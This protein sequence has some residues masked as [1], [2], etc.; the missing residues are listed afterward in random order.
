MI[1][2]RTRAI[3][4]VVAIEAWHETFDGRIAKADLHADVSFSLGRMG[5]QA[6]ARISFRLALRQAEVVLIVPESEGLK[7]D[8]KSV[9]REQTN[10]KFEASSTSKS[11]SSRQ[12]MA[13]VKGAIGLKPKLDLNGQLKASQ[14][15][16]RA[17]T[18]KTT[19]T[20]PMIVAHSQTSDGHHCWKI[21]AMREDGLAGQPW[22]PSK[23]R[24]TLIDSQAGRDRSIVPCVR[25]EVRCRREDLII[26]DIQV[27]DFTLLEQL[28]AAVLHRN[29][30]V[31][32]ECFIRD[33]LLK[34]GLGFSDLNNR[35]ATIVLASTT[36]DA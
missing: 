14:T 22:K 25:L 4:E 33:E 10:V 7:I 23:A 2:N 19:V 35:F 36:T 3:A 34:R 29:K 21:E 27:V 32:A 1:G 11:K 20:Q 16:E 13:A 15:I 30:E 26:S 31:A 28:K 5:D 12:I 6:G 8:P 9:D 18:T 24:A 17:R